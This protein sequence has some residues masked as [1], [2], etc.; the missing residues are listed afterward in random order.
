MRV[1]KASKVKPR[2]K[3]VKRVLA[4]L[5]AAM[6]VL[7]ISVVLLVPTFIS[8]EKGRRIILA[9]INDSIAGKAD[10]SDL[11]M[12]WLK[13]VKLADLTFD[14]DAG[15]VSVRVGQVS[16]KPSYAA[17][18]TGNLAFGETVID[19]PSVEINLEDLQAA[20]PEIAAGKPPA[21]EAAQPIA[22]PVK[23]IDLVLNDGNVKITDPQS[24]TTE[25]SRINS[26]VSLQ[27]PGLRTD[28]DLKMDVSRADKASAV[29]VA[30]HVTPKRKTGWSLKG[31]SGNLT[32]EV[33]DLDLE[34]LGPIFALAG[35]DI[36]SKGVAG[37]YL[38]S[39]IRDGRFEN[40]TASIKAKNLDVT[41]E[42]LKGDRFQTTGLDISTKLNQGDRAAT[43][44]MLK[45]ES[46]WASVTASGMVPT[47]SKSIGDFFQADSSYDLKADLDCDVAAILS[48][49]PRTL[50]LKE[51]TQVTS[52]RL[53]AEVET[54]TEAGKRQIRANAT[55]AAL[56]AT[57]DGRKAALSESITAEAFVSSDK[58]GITFD[59]LDVTA[60][61]AVIS[62]TGRI[63]ELDY[64]AQAD[65]AKLQSELGQFIDLGKYR[66]AGE[67]VEKGKISVTEDSITASGSAQIRNLRLSSQDRPS[68]SDPMT[69]I[70]FALGVDIKNNF[71]ALDSIKAD[72]SFGA[73]SVKDGVIPLSEKSTKPLHVVVSA[74]NVD[75]AKLKPF[76]VL[77]EALPQEM[78]LAG[79]VES[80]LSVDAEKKIYKI[81]TDST[82]IERLKLA[83]PD[84][85]KPFEPNEVALAFDVEIGLDGAINARSLKLESELIKIDKAEFSRTT[86]ADRAILAG[87]AELEYDWSA[88]SA[89]AAPYLP[90]GL[91]LEGMRKDAVSFRSAYSAA[92]SEKLM[93]NLSAIARLGFKRAGYMGLNFGSTDVDIQVLNGLLKIEPIATTVNEGLF[94]FAGQADFKAEPALFKSAGPMQIV[95]DIK[96]NDE[97]T[98]K[99]LKYVNPIFANAVNVSGIANF[100]CEQLAIPLKARAKNDAVVIGTISMR[101]VR[102]QASNLMGQIIALT[103]GDARGTE[104]TVH[105]TRFVLRKGFLRYGDMQVDIGDNPVNFK[106]VIGL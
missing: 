31:T 83:H 60:P 103:G 43:I 40:L 20:K 41:G 94:S 6:V 11:S 21:P 54:S 101:K 102:L 82:R 106:G 62:C 10:F 75:L 17:L 48:Q 9:R 18:L 32:V 37:G 93:P 65:L 35:I 29:Q 89:L 26:K 50:G 45:I 24:G 3:T 63:E 98:S 28:F 52:G 55:L 78:Q 90:E 34:S 71:I 99:L 87:K 95:K 67:I 33:N 80:T 85:E 36:R 49:M 44:D 27:P 14:D 2:K 88:V 53:T 59:K 104:M 66:M 100:S 16:T 58:A 81:A 25:L 46:D 69:N 12:G 13:G 74:G 91:K 15:R 79:I 38:K 19:K 5:I 47:T 39:Q 22:L 1:D 86:E 72:A 8:S 96:I 23:S 97:T 77:F 68:A 4:L 30:G 51:G 92:Q 76:A 7:A 61:F 42:A 57:A 70:D 105:P 84:H 56:E 64:D 73:L